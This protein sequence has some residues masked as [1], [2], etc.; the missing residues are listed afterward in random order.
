MFKQIC[1]A[2]VTALCQQEMKCE[3]EFEINEDRVTTVCQEGL[4]LALGFW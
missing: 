3:K 4:A 2:G 1:G